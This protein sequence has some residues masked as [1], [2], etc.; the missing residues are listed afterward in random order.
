MRRLQA[1][2]VRCRHG[3]LPCMHAYQHTYTYIRDHYLGI[4]GVDV[5]CFL[6]RNLIVSLLALLIR[7]HIYIY[8]ADARVIKL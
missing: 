3:L 4:D 7:I 8:A 6:Y 2:R 5:S 1:E